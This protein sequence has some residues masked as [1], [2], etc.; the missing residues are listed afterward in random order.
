MTRADWAL[1]SD[2]ITFRRGYSAG[3]ASC[4]KNPHLVL[5]LNITFF[6]FLYFFAIKANTLP[7]CYNCNQCVEN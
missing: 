7:L 3:I 5:F 2:V 4:C 1:G 6:L